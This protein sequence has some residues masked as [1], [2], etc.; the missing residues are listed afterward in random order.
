[1]IFYKTDDVQNT[2]NKKLTEVADIDVDVS[3]LRDRD[4]FNFL[5]HSHELD[6]V[7]LILDTKTN[8]Y[9]HVYEIQRL[10]D[11]YRL[12]VEIDVL[13]TYKDIILNSYV[14]AY[15]YNERNYS[16]VPVENDVRRYSDIYKGSKTV[17]G[18]GSYILVTLGNQ[19]SKYVDDVGG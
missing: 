3:H 4:E 9:Y 15:K 16:N 11:F 18:D 14:K 10:N 17:T 7:N 1:M 12:Y 8:I 5:V 13:M 2:V 19:N 6:E